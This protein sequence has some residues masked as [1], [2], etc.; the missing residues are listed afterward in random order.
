ME[1]LFFKKLNSFINNQFLVMIFLFV[2]Y[3]LYRLILLKLDVFPFNSDEAIVGLMGKHILDGESPLY[4]YGQSYMGSLD[5]YLVALSFLIFGE[6]VIAIRLVQIF[7]F[8]VTILIIYF[9]VIIAF[10]NLKA[11]FFSALF[12]IFSPLNVI[13]YTTV[14]L[15]GYVEALLIGSVLLL[16]SGL[17]LRE[18]ENHVSDGKK[19]KKLLLLG[20]LFTGIGMWVNPISLTMCIP[21]C[22]CFLLNKKHEDGRTGEVIKK[23]IIIV[24]GFILGSFFWWYPI[25]INNNLIYLTELFGSA[26]SV[27]TGSYLQNSFQHLISFV[28]F[29]PTAVFGM[30]PPWDVF[31]IGKIFVPVVLLFW[32]IVFAFILSNEEEITFSIKWAFLCLIGIVLIIFLGFVFTSFG[33]D[34]SGRYFLPVYIPLSIWAGFAISKFKKKLLIFLLGLF[35]IFYQTFGVVTSANQDPFLTTQF[36]NPA[37]IDQSFM[38]ELISFL[39]INEE[40]Y[41]FSNYWVSYPLAFLTNE[42]IISLPLLPYH[43]DLTYTSRDNRILKYNDLIEKQNNYFYITTNNPDLD[44]LLIRKFYTA[45]ITYDFEKIGDFHIFYNLSKS[46]QPMMLGLNEE[47]R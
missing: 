33:V 45:K 35:V 31:I 10:R 44:N 42:E 23:I 20:G 17:V 34:P 4:F 26:V 19:V 29:A 2:L 6:K 28:L 7:L 12:L 3:F 13:L 9:Y 8:F 40:Y 14:S 38:D 18:Y 15:G 25:I 5:A 36:Y 39:K 24:I 16:I 43:T 41:G 22:L 30:R 32:I 46:V 11:A 21:A 27:E 37:Q 47:F 1:K